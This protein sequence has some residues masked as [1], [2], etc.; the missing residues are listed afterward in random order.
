MSAIGP[1][2]LF[3][4]LLPFAVDSGGAEAACLRAAA[5]GGDPY[6]QLNLG[7]AYDQGSGVER[8]V[9][10]ALHWYRLA[11][12]QEVAEAEFNLGHLLASHGDA[13]AGV[14]WLARAAKQGLVDAQYMLGVLYAE[15][16]GVSRDTNQALKWLR[17][18][19][20]Q[21]HDAA[22]DYL[23]MQFPREKP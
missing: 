10:R 6:A 20:G 1:A 17:L 19:K 18:A 3:L 2:L 9:T 21:G 22:A 4:V 12:K 5:E 11:A 23:R 14:H 8:D 15:G 7:A 13:A 16:E